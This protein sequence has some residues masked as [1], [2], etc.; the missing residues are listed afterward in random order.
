MVN[1]YKYV[2]L[3]LV[4]SVAVFGIVGPMLI[5]SAST[6]GVVAGVV[7]LLLFPVYAF[8]NVKKIVNV[9]KNMG[10]GIEK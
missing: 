1:L 3:L 5:S 8:W 2:V 4:V 10:K 7:L 6:E 9:V